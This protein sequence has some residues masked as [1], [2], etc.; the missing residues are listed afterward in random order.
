MFKHRH[1]SEV[2]DESNGPVG[3]HHRKQ[4][5]RSNRAQFTAHSL[6]LTIA[7]GLIIGSAGLVGGLTL[8]EKILTELANPLG[9]VWMLLMLLAYFCFLMRQTW[10]AIVNLFCWLLLTVAGNSL[11]SNWLI[12]TLEAPYAHIDALKLDKF[13][14]LIVLG[15]GTSYRQI[16]R[17]QFSDGGDRIGL[18]ARMYHA[19][20]ADRIICTG[21]T[22]FRSSEDE[23]QVREQSAELLKGLLV[24]AD[25]IVLVQGINTS[26]EMANL[27]KHF[28]ALSSPPARVGI[29]TSA[30]HLSRAMRLAKQNGLELIPVPADVKSGPYRLSP[31]L[32]IPSS[33]YLERT[34]IAI[35]EYLAWCVGR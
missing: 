11:I 8:V 28:Q 3:D 15:G 32:L 17:S 18:T 35:K 6:A 5:C 30:Y 14:Y 22:S 9:L 24:P 1:Q 16:G 2:C 13:D 21:S 10:P 7:G 34:K 27:R 4:P 29:V 20:K 12:S 26:Q 25:K 23:P 19:G 31:N 33:G